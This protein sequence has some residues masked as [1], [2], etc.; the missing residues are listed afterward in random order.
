VVGDGALH[1]EATVGTKRERHGSL[2]G[3]P[4]LGELLRRAQGPNGARGGI[5]RVGLLRH[6]LSPL[7]RRDRRRPPRPG[8]ACET[9]E[10]LRGKTPAPA[11]N[12]DCG[13]HRDSRAKSNKSTDEHARASNR[14]YWHIDCC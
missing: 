2:A 13:I 3:R 4:I 8:L 11:T 9:D 14:S 5:S 10:P 6:D 7:A 1:R 12:F